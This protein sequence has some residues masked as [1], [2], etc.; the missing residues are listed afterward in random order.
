MEET[1]VQKFERSLEYD[2]N[3]DHDS[4]SDANLENELEESLKSVNA[5]IQQMPL[6]AEMQE[7]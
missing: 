5:A 3:A 1:E 6:N 7:V 2:Y 4:K